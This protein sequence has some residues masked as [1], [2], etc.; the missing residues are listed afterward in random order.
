MKPYQFIKPLL[1]FAAFLVYISLHSCNIQKSLQKGIDSLK[2][3]VPLN[4]AGPPAD[5]LVRGISANFVMGISD[6]SKKALQI[7]MQNLN[8]SVDQLDPAVKKLLNAISTMGDT[9]SLQVK[10][11]GNSI[12]W[13]VGQLNGD[14][15]I[16][17]GTLRKL[18]D[19]LKNDTKDILANI[20]QN[21]LDS[22]QTPASKAKIDSIIAN[23]LD[24]NTKVKARQ[25]L[26]YALQP[27]LDSLAS[28]EHT[29]V[30]K[31]LPFVQKRATGLLIALGAIAIAIIGFVWYERSRYARL[32]K[33]LT[34]QIDK[35]PREHSAV[36]DDLTS[37]IQLHAKSDGLEPLLSK[38]LKD[39][40]INT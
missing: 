27:A 14:I 6:S 23:I 11:I 29:L 9:T 34:F 8:T 10:K 33:V 24:Q 21:A 4:N 31:D 28:K 22:F 2:F 40:S 39:Q 25:F 26:S 5:S 13:Q 1:L 20:I 37:R 17:G 3:K 38:T 15:K 16:M 36:Y 12:H 30:Y 18:T 35:I 7:I 32:V 19:S